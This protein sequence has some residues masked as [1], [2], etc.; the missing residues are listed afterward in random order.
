MKRLIVLVAALFFSCATTQ[1]QTERDVYMDDGTLVFDSG[2][3]TQGFVAGDTVKIH[4][5]V[6]YGLAADKGLIPPLPP[7]RDQDQ[8]GGSGACQ[9]TCPNGVTVM[10]WGW[11]ENLCACSFTN[12]VLRVQCIAYGC[13]TLEIRCSHD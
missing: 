7:D 1:I 11:N 10:L 12:G 6:L 2:F 13:P 5:D 8:C 4:R 3:L 9:G